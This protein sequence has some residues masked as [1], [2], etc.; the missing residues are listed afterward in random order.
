MHA[1]LRQ[2]SEDVTQS[3]TSEVLKPQNGDIV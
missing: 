3:V 2:V 1:H